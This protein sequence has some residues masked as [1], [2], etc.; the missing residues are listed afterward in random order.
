MPEAVVAVHEGYYLVEVAAV[1]IG[2]EYLSE[3]FGGHRL[4]DAADASGVQLVENV[5]K[6]K[7]WPQAAGA[8]QE[9][10]LRETQRDGERLALTLRG[11]AA[12]GQPVE[13]KFEVVAVRA[14]GGVAQHG[15]AGE[16]LAEQCFQSRSGWLQMALKADGCLLRRAGN[17]PIVAREHRAKLLHPRVARGGYNSSR[18]VHLEVYRLEKSGIVGAVAQQA[19][20]LL[21]QTAVAHDGV[22]VAG[23]ALTDDHVHEAAAFVACAAYQLHIG[24]TD[25][26][27]R[28]QADVGAYAAVFLAASLEALAAAG[29]K[30][31]DYLLGLPETLIAAAHDGEVLA[32]A[33]QHGVR[34]AGEALREAEQIQRVKQVALAHAIVAQQ[35]VDPRRELEARPRDVLEIRYVK[36]A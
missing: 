34:R 1:G 8:A 3:T 13:G 22:E 28:Q 18:G 35:A 15:V 19:V 5:V 23:I 32:G 30:A 7:Q 24:R 31:G 9:I 10:V 33:H 14:D 36:L 4:D 17:S 26:H 12:H 2:N 6:Q 20:A 21:E 16:S 11:R 25:H 27:K 29:L